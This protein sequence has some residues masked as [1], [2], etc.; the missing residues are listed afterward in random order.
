MGRLRIVATAALLLS[1]CGG[2]DVQLTTWG[3]VCDD[4]A[5]AWCGAAEGCGYQAGD[6]CR[7]HTVSHCCTIWGECDRAADADQISRGDVC[8]AALGQLDDD[9]CYWL[10]WGLAPS[11]CNDH[12]ADWPTGDQ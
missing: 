11:E 12:F 2:D 9:G 7:A 4:F 10:I 8:D 5:E 3:D 1:A 6:V